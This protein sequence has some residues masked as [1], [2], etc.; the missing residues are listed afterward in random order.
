MAQGHI[1]KIVGGWFQEHTAIRDEFNRPS[2]L[3]VAF[4]QIIVTKLAA[5]AQAVGREHPVPKISERKLARLAR[6]EAISGAKREQDREE[7]LVA[8]LEKKRAAAAGDAVLNHEGS[9]KDPAPQKHEDSQGAPVNAI[10][11]MG[12]G[13][14]AEENHEAGERENARENAVRC[15]AHGVM[16]GLTVSSKSQT[17]ENPTLLQNAGGSRKQARLMSSAEGGA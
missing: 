14:T 2:E 11:S 10:G 4:C 8:A 9:Q 5:A 3:S 1:H 17:D 16:Q 7:R 15:T 12:V 13:G 6:E